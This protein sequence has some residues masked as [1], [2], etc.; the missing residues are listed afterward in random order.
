MNENV[1]TMIEQ[2]VLTNTQAYWVE[3]FK[4]IDCCFTPVLPPQ[5]FQLIPPFYYSQD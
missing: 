5:P 3:R 1:K 2:E 4:D